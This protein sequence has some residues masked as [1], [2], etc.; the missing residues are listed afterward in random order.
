VEEEDTSEHLTLSEV[1]ERISQ[2]VER[3]NELRAVIDGILDEV[4]YRD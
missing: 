2:T 3:E 4:M 1:R